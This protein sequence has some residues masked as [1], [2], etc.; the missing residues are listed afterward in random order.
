VTVLGLDTLTA[1]AA[2][3]PCVSRGRRAWRA[4]TLRGERTLGSVALGTSALLL[5]VMGACGWWS[6][7]VARDAA[8]A[9]KGEQIR[10]IG[11]TLAPRIAGL[12]AAGDAAGVRRVIVESAADFGLSPCRVTLGAAVGSVADV[13]PAVPTLRAVPANWSAG[14]ADPS[15]EPT[16]A[17]F[18]VIVPGRGLATLEI[19]GQPRGANQLFWRVQTGVGLIGAAA[20]ASV[21]LAY[22]RTRVRLAGTE[23][24]VGALAAY[25]GG[26]RSTDAMTIDPTLGTVA[27]A[28]NDVMA[29]VDRSARASV[30]TRAAAGVR[31]VEQRRQGDTSELEVACG[32]ITQGLLLVDEDLRVRFANGAAAVF[33]GKGRDECVGRTAAELIGDPAVLEP[34]RTLA[35]RTTRSSVTVES[36]RP[37]GPGTVGSTLRFTIRPFRKDDEAACLITIDDITSQRAAERARNSFVEQVTHELRTPLTTIRLYTE[38]AIETG[39]SADAESAAMRA[40]CLNVINV[41]SRRLERI[42]GEM[43]SIAEIEAGSLT[44]RRDEVRLPELFEELRSDYA[45]QATDKELTLEMALPPKLPTI[46]ADR[47][48]LAIAYHNLIGNALKYTPAGGKVTVA[49]QVVADVLTVAVQDSGI[50]IAPEEQDRVFERFYRSTDPRVGEIV[51]TGLGL[52]LA[53]EIVRQHGGDITLDSQLNKGSTFTATVPIRGDA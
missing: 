2:R 24:V 26:E 6:A 36:E 13:D 53:R 14:P 32:V 15:A 25:A 39:A 16:V 45:A 30:A 42:V 7:T 22:R 49:V 40:N 5:A 48:K 35:T 11:V 3:R 27:A 50:G 51:G 19:G 8:A 34:L 47:D 41:E 12:L 43:L 46:L 44:I 52:P 28:W 23:A 29:A 4:V 37:A 20:L 17:R 1:A 18:P 10:T 31:G 9:A 33:V 21:L 38:T